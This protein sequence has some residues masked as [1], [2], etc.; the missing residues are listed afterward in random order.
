MSTRVSQYGVI[1]SGIMY[2]MV[3][4]RWEEIARHEPNDSC[5]KCGLVFSDHPRPAV[6]GG[7]VGGGAWQ[8]SP[9]FIKWKQYYRPVVVRPSWQRKKLRKF[10]AMYFCAEC[11]GNQ[12]W[13]F[14][15]EIYEVL[16]RQGMEVSQRLDAA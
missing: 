2:K 9:E 1:G 10:Q 15:E 13:N 8:Q 6:A 4:G 12:T 5:P 7:H 14:S 16:E 11:C 3:D